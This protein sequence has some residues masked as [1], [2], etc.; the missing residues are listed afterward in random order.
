[1]SANAIQIESPEE[2]Y[3]ESLAERL[4]RRPL[5]VPEALRYAT[6]IA[7]TLR[8]LHAQGLVYGAVSSHLI[9]LSPS[10]A[11]LRHTGG[12]TRLGGGQTDVAAFG[13]V[14]D[15]MLYRKISLHTEVEALREELFALARHCA[16]DAPEMRQVLIALRILRLQARQ[17]STAIRRPVA[18][19]PV[20]VEEAVPVMDMLRDS[21]HTAMQWRPLANLANLA[22]FALSGK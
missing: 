13:T 8:D 21:L 10:G 17:T 20:P 15:D 7:T 2:A 3:Q 4:A 16:E 9:L 6:E 11:S 12:L 22:T 1:M 5:P 18:P 19:P 14:L